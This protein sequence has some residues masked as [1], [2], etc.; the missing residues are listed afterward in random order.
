MG[1]SKDHYFVIICE[2]DTSA[3]LSL[4]LECLDIPRLPH[5]GLTI[6]KELAKNEF[7]NDINCKNLANTH[8]V[9]CHQK[10]PQY[11]KVVSG[12]KRKNIQG[13]DI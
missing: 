3:V 7:L 12:R 9:A 4:N 11:V 6:L 8:G 10:S 13:D 5:L 1:V 2:Q